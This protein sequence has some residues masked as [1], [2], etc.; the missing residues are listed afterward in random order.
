MKIAS[1]VTI[2]FVLL[3]AAKTVGEAGKKPGQ[4][5]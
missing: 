5:N 3:T 4:T 1:I 2:F